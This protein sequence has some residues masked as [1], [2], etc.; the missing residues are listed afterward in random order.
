MKFSWWILYNP[1]STSV[2][3]KQLNKITLHLEHLRTN[4]GLPQSIHFSLA[5]VLSFFWLQNIFTGEKPAI[6]SSTKGL[7]VFGKAQNRLWRL[8]KMQNTDVKEVI[9]NHNENQSQYGGRG[10][11]VNNLSLLIFNWIGKSCSKNH[12]CKYE[13]SGSTQCGLLCFF[14]MCAVAQAFFSSLKQTGNVR[15]GGQ[16]LEKHSQVAAT[17]FVKCAFPED[18]I[19]YMHFWE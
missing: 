18:C 16:L 1:V 15:G 14:K 12:W 6:Y 8:L 9:V 17:L 4:D 13:W 19:F 11:T 5:M 10:L 2:S 3:S 7:L